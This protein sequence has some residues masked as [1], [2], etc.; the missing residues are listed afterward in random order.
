LD[1]LGRKSIIGKPTGI[2]LKGKKLTL[3]LIY[4]LKQ[5]DRRESRRAL[6]IIRGGAKS[7]E[8]VWIAD[9]VRENGGIDYAL[10]K[11]EHYAGLAR[12]NLVAIPQSPA[13]DALLLFVDYVTD[14]ET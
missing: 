8:I 5:A 12:Q 14:R 9:F 6:G 10:S 11:A 7:R 1:Y 13:R 3:P 2:D 4:A